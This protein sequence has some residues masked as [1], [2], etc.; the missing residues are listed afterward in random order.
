MAFQIL[1]N[2]FIAVVWMFLSS[3]MTVTTFVIG[4]IIGLILLIMMRRFFT[5]SLYFEWLWAAFKL[6]LLFI[7]EL[8]LSNIDVLR[9]VLRPK[10]NIQPRIFALPT[11]LKRDWE[12]TLLSS[13][14]TLTPGT[15]VVHVSDDQKTLY[16]HAIDADDVQDA[17]DSIKNTFEK[18]IKEVS[19]P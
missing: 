13:L 15:V 12:I 5:E 11:E 14:I 19:R 4:Y 6:T 9:V 7:R 10:L 17:I 1:L 8:T 16:V 2:F 3:S 18:A